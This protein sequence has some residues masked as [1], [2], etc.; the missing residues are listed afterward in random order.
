MSKTIK[1]IGGQDRWPELAI[2]GKQSVW[3]RGQSEER[4]DA[5]ANALLQTGLFL[6]SS[7]SGV[8]L[9]IDQSSNRPFALAGDSAPR[10]I[11]LIG[12]EEAGDRL[13]KPS[14][15]ASVGYSA[16]SLWQ[17]GGSIFKP[18]SAPSNTSAL[19][20]RQPRQGG[21]IA[22]VM[23]ANCRFAGGTVAM[24]AGY[25]GNAIDV[26]VKVGGADVTETITILSGGELDADKVLGLLARADANTK[27][28][29]TQIYDQTGLG[30]HIVKD[31]A[32][33]APLLDWDE[34]AGRFV[35]TGDYD[36]TDNIARQLRIPTTL[37]A[38]RNNWSAFALGRA[39]N[40]CADNYNNIILTLGD[41]QGNTNPTASWLPAVDGSI[42]VN[43]TPTGGGWAP[44]QKVPMPSGLMVAGVSSGATLKAFSNERS[45]SGSN[46]SDASL[47]TGGWIG[48]DN[49]TNIRRIP[50]RFFGIAICNTAVTDAQIE[51]I[52][53]GFYARFDV[54]PQVLDR[55]VIL[56][57]S[58]PAGAFAKY[59]RT[60]AIQ[61]ADRLGK[62]AEVVN[63]SNGSYTI[64]QAQTTM[65]PTAKTIVRTGRK[66][67]AIIFAGVNNFIVGN[68]TPQQVVTEMAALVADLKGAG[69][70]VIVLGELAT[71]STVNGANTKLPQLRDLL[72]GNPVGADSVVMLDSYPEVIAANVAAN[73][74]DGLHPSAALFG[75]I[76]GALEPV[77]D[78]YLLA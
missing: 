3:S 9:F 37:T 6:Q 10:E 1:Y 35:V 23:G 43:H 76:A 53:T 61:L 18:A 51:V 26:T 28:T 21:H 19:W 59:F 41:S 30:N 36:N 77:V 48:S 39:V 74:P 68:Q 58:R 40:A 67:I 38:N 71:T 64:S 16:S 78:R 25:V 8:Q 13:P 69:Y 54:A 27:A 46:L 73:Y 63:L 72:R 70:K 4:D 2:T 45:G 29:V 52:K 65:A 11:A 12:E 50:V 22:N 7:G 66:N 32:Y 55:V 5:E 20:V 15:N 56:G 62:R 24:K 34:L 17:H 49:G 47:L 14:D 33:A 57:D 75:L 42:L 31:A 44:T 60:V